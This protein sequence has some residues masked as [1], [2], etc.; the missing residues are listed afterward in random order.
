MEEERQIRFKVKRGYH[1]ST[2]FGTQRQGT[3][4]AVRNV[5]EDGEGVVGEMVG[6][7]PIVEFPCI[8]I[9]APVDVHGGSLR[10]SYVANGSVHSR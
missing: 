6:I 10:Y 9:Y 8:E 3:G 1:H 7:Q 4:I 5:G 2:M